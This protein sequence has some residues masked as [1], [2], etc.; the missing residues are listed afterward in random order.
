MLV[1]LKW[2][3]SMAVTFLFHSIAFLQPLIKDSNEGKWKVLIGLQ[4][5]GC[6][7]VSWSC[8]VSQCRQMDCV[9]RAFQFQFLNDPQLRPFYKYKLHKMLHSALNYTDVCP[10]RVGWCFRQEMY[11]RLVKRAAR[12]SNN[13]NVCYS[14]ANTISTRQ[15]WLWIDS[16][17]P[18]KAFGES[19]VEDIDDAHPLWKQLH[20]LRL[21]VQCLSL[22]L[23]WYNTLHYQGRRVC[24]GTFAMY[25]Q[26][27]DDEPS[28]A[29]VAHPMKVD[30]V[31]CFVVSKFAKYDDG[32]SVI[33]R[34]SHYCVHQ[35]LLINQL[36]VVPLVEGTRF[37]PYVGVQLPNGIVK[38]VEEH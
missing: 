27:E 11:L 33:Y 16:K 17:V 8:K 23:T 38:L 18:V 6:W 5:I 24:K 19:G 4:T 7:V 2:T 30:S 36:L 1:G 3:G 22:K 14:V 31:F 29:V 25:Q 28:I 13:V 10:I 15:S 9:I 21:G 32:S 26:S 12:E 34:D 37:S 20:G 35:S